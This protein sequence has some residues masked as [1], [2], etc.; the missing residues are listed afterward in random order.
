MTKKI[1][2]FLSLD[3]RTV[4]LLELVRLLEHKDHFDKALLQDI[5]DTAK[6]TTGTP[7]DKLVYRATLLDGHYKL[8][9]ALQQVHKSIT[10]LV[11]IWAWGH[12]MLGITLVFGLLALPVI[13]FFYLFIAL[14]GWHTLSLILWL[15]TTY[16]NKPSVIGSMVTFFV[17]TLQLTLFTKL[18]IKSSCPQESLLGTYIPQAYFTGLT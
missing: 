15:V 2:G 10:L 11:R 18:P 8:A 4:E 3:S 13:N 17:N 16:Q 6:K 9:I 12:F 1:G 14:L 5:T 7:L